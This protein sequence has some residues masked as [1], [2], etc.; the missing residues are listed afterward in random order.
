MTPSTNE[1]DVESPHR[2]VVDSNVWI[3]AL[4]FGGAPRRIFEQIVRDGLRLV[5]S[6][7]IESEIRRILATKFPVFADD[8]EAM[9][10]A[11]A[12]FTS[13]VALGGIT[14]DVCRDPD[15]NRV[16]ETAV[17]GNAAVV[18]SGDRD[19]LV[20]ARHDSVSIVTPSAWLQGQGG[21]DT[22]STEAPDT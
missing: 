4:V 2:V 15:D 7:H 9:R 8:F 3:S 21:T 6:P 12:S 5:T 22:S 19:L 1:S 11:L 10:V 18:V 14:I 13:V 20:L 17:L 16:L